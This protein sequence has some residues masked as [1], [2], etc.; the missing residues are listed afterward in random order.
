MYMKE[1]CERDGDGC[2]EFIEQYVEYIGDDP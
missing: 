2:L 1:E